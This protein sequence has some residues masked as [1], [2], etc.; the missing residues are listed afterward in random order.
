MK[1]SFVYSLHYYFC[2]NLCCY[3]ISENDH[4]VIGVPL[5]KSDNSYIDESHSSHS[6]LLSFIR[7]LEFIKDTELQ[8]STENKTFVTECDFVID[9]FK[10]YPSHQLEMI[11]SYESNA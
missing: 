6:L 4:K 7:H 2:F 5:N 10:F 11:L 3:S 9:F 1:M 8:H